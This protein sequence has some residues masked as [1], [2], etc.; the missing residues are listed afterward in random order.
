S[1]AVTITGRILEG[2]SRAVPSTTPLVRWVARLG[3]VMQGAVVVATPGAIWHRVWSHLMILIYG[4][5]LLLLGAALLFG[6]ADT[7][8]TAVAAL[9]ATVAIHL[10][11]LVLGDFIRGR[12]AWQ[13]GLLVAAVLAVLAAAGVGAMA[14]WQWGPGVLCGPPDSGEP[15]A[16]LAALCPAPD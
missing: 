4:F 11:K 2:V 12:R 1:R 7:R 3:L 13:R 16:A 15:P 6:G 5:E 9:V 8:S 10:A 14:L